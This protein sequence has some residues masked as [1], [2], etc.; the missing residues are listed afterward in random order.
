MADTSRIHSLVERGRR[1]LK[2]QAALEGAVLAVIP[3]AAAAAGVVFLVRS[4]TL[5]ESAGLG[6]LIGCSAL[7]VIGGVAG[8]LRRVPTSTIATRIDRA[9]GL[10]DRLATACAFED[11][12]RRGFTG[13][14]ETRAFMQAA[15]DDAVRAAPRANVVAA[16]RFA[17]PRDTR[18]ALAFA[19]AAA[20]VCGLY[21]APIE[22]DPIVAT[23]APP[24]APRG[25]E[26]VLSGV[27]FADDGQV[28][29]G[30]AAGAPAFEVV[31]WTP[32]R[33]RARVPQGAAV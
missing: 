28:F 24:A 32:K 1:R 30:E 13:D 33:V 11:E 19:A 31:E 14:E 21:L 18:A 20:V 29:A 3:A 25:A 23:I 8:W 27:R 2:L 15:I 17:W 26:V 9:S 12:L 5:P 16:T 10:S 22:R 6:F 7:V 4:E